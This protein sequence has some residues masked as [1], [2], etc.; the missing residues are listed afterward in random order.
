MVCSVFSPVIKGGHKLDALQQSLE[1]CGKAKGPA[2][3]QVKI[4]HLQSSKH[5]QGKN[6]ILLKIHIVKRPLGGSLHSECSELLI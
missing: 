2:W 3:I 4:R 6:I 1:R 5:L